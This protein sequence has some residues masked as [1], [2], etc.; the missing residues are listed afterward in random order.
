M[1]FITPDNQP[2]QAGAEAVEGLVLGVRHPG[3]Q[4]GADSGIQNPASLAAAVMYFPRT[5]VV[6]STMR[7][8]VLLLKLMCV[9]L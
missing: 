1:E 7:Q 6:V 3:S 2:P 5:F 9:M 8:T 4:A